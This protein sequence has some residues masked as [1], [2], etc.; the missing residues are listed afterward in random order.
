M[1]AVADE[2]QHHVVGGKML[3]GIIETGCPVHILQGMKDP[4][5]IALLLSAVKGIIRSS[6]N[7]Q[8]PA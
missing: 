4:D 2:G 5:D 3:D 1:V 8:M 7:R 6:T